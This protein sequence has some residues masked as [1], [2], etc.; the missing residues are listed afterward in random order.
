[1]AGVVVRDANLGRVSLTASG[2]ASVAYEP[3]VNELKAIAK[4]VEVLGSMWFNLGAK[5][6][7]VPHR[8]YK[9][10]VESERYSLISGKDNFR[11]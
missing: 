9:Y 10:N 2:R 1:M 5:R 4:G 11:P 6:I 8:E 7:I 3:G